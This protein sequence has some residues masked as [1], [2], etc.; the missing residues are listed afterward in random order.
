MNAGCSKFLNKPLG[1]E[2]LHEIMWRHFFRVSSI[3]Y[4]QIYQE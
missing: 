3:E 1:Y 4:A 2:K